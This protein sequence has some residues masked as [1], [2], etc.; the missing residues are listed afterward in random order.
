MLRIALP[1]AWRYILAGAVILSGCGL[2]LADMQHQATKPRGTIT[3]IYVGADD[4][5][6][7]RAWRKDDQPAFFG[8]AAFQKI[9]YREVITSHLYDLLAE[10]QWPEDLSF[11]RERVKARPGAPQWF[12]M[13]NG[14]MIIWETGLSA[15]PRVVWPTIQA[16]TADRQAS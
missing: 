13:Q 3:V 11:V 14:R 8:S 1:V 15:W 6:P 16:Q 4:C 12:V 10:S 2:L 9:K 7:C 5:A